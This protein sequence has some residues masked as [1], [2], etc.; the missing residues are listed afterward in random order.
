MGLGLTLFTISVLFRMLSLVTK[1]YAAEKSNIFESLYLTNIQVL[2]VTTLFVLI[3]V[4][5]GWYLSYSNY[6]TPWACLFALLVISNIVVEIF[7]HQNKHNFSYP[8]MYEG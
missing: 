1:I 2:H 3:S 8:H 4:A 5:C 7:S 6:K